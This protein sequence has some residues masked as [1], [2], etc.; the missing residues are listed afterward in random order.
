MEIYVDD[1]SKLTLHGLV[2]HYVKLTEE[3]KN[4]K[5]SHI[6][7]FLFLESSQSGLSELVVTSC[8]F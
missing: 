4:R 5:A 6:I 7:Q 2:Q 1:E 8:L 3:Q